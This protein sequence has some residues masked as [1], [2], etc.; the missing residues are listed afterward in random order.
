MTT[1]NCFTLFGIYLLQQWL[2]CA[3]I[4]LNRQNINK[5]YIYSSQWCKWPLFMHQF[6]FNSLTINYFRFIKWVI[7]KFLLNGT[8]LLR[9]FFFSSCCSLRMHSLKNHSQSTSQKKIKSP[10]KCTKLTTM[11]R[12]ES[13]QWRE[14]KWMQKKSH[15]NIEWI[16]LLFTFCKVIKNRRHGHSGA[17]Y[18]WP[19]NTLIY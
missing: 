6:I 2:R 17:V 10:A 7:E 16:R 19:K 3:E 9:R 14:C 13:Q 4:E 11:S 15:L 12:V 1:K 8:F 18:T 5:K